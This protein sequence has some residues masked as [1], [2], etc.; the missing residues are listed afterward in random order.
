VINHCPFYSASPRRHRCC[1][2]SS[3]PRRGDVDLLLELK[4]IPRPRARRQHV[5]ALYND[6]SQP[7]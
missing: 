2:R 5:E 1:R 4:R 3:I 6:T 7:V